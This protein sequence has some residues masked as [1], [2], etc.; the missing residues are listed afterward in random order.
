MYRWVGALLKNAG[1]E[2]LHGALVTSPV[3]AAPPVAPSESG[4]ASEGGS[5]AAAPGAA[6]LTTFEVSLLD[7]LVRG[8]RKR[9]WRER[10][11]LS[12]P[13]PPQSARH[14]FL[15]ALSARRSIIQDVGPAFPRFCHVFW[16]L[17][18]ACQQHEDSRAAQTVLVSRGR[19]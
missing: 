18:D 15:R 4:D 16:W 14:A 17:L 10:I 6:P 2:T 5:A 11:T 13:L 9:S 19:R 7:E 12:L 1:A 3:A 8:R